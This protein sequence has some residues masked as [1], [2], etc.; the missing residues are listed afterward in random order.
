MAL[1]DEGTAK[2]NVDD[3]FTYDGRA[4]AGIDP[5]GLQG[6]ADRHGVP[7]SPRL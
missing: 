1:P 5:E 7:P 2:L 3:A 6:R 4:G